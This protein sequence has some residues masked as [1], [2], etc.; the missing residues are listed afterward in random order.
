LSILAPGHYSVLRSAAIE[1]AVP[2]QKYAKWRGSA[3]AAHTGCGEITEDGNCGSDANLRVI[4]P[5]FGIAKTI[6]DLSRYRRTVGINLALEGLRKHRTTPAAIAKL[7]VEA[8][9][10]NTMEAYLI[11]LRPNA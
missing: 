10:W 1:C 5:I 8:G 11:A 4:A 7:T 3:H 6:T 2:W 9:V